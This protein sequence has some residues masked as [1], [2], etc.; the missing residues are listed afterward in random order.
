MA[1]DF[2]WSQAG[3]TTNIQILTSAIWNTG[4]RHPPLQS[5][6]PRWWRRR[7]LPEGHYVWAPEGHPVILSVLS[8]QCCSDQPLQRG[9][10]DSAGVKWQLSFL[11]SPRQE[12]P[13]GGLP[14]RVLPSITQPQATSKA[15]PQML[16]LNSEVAAL[17][18]RKMGR[19]QRQ[20]ISEELHPVTYFLQGGYISLRFLSLPNSATCWE[21][22]IQNCELRM[23]FHIQLQWIC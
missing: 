18:C 21:P 9:R 16:S 3:Q 13:A 7:L 4:K 6:P 22:Y 12:V 2:H 8:S 5:V 15:M 14:S 11:K 10:W 19:G 1:V 20:D 23:V 17:T